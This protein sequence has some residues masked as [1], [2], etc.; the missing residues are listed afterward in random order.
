MRKLFLLALAALSLP[1]CAQVFNMEQ[2]RVQIT[3]LDGPMRFHTGDDPRWSQP[4]FDD[5]AW[6][7]ISPESNWS[8]QG[9]KDYGGFAWYRFKVILPPSTR[10]LPSTFPPSGPATRSLPMA[11][12]WAPSAA[13]RR[14]G[15]SDTSIPQRV[16]LPPTQAGAIE[17]AIRV[18]HWPH[19]AMYF[20]GGLSGAPRIGD[21]GQLKEWMTLQ[22]RNT[23]WQLTAQDYLALLNFL[24]A[25]AGFALFLMRRRER[26]Y[27]W[28]GLAGFFFGGWSL[29][30]GFAAFHAVPA[31]A[32][33]AL[34]DG[35]SVAG[36]LSF[37]MFVWMMLGAR[38]TMWIPVCI[39]SVALDVVMWTVPALRN[40]PV[41]VGN[42]IF[43]A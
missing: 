30:N 35:L 4:A 2:G 8:A 24:Y 43:L 26:L 27:L 14:T 5:S 25:I 6:P 7:L 16:L 20:G 11:S 28:Y 36:F 9:Y 23:F 29:A 42:F 40:L 12:W 39:V 32:S 37:L 19:W 33:E 38:R 15:P 31:F 18:W 34:M 10:S 17:I 3:P 41:S 21:A 1:A 13:F 22:D